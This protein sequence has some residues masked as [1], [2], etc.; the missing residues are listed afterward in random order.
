MEH[1]CARE[2]FA[3]QVGFFRAVL[4]ATHDDPPRY[5]TTQALGD[6][7]PP[8]VAGRLWAQLEYE[9]TRKKK[10]KKK[11]KKEK[12]RKRKKIKER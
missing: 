1:F 2:T 8:T 7:A 4:L 11:K 10:K 3:E 9:A 6:S 12:E 5:F